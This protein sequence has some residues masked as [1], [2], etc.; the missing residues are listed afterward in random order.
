VKETTLEKSLKSR[1]DFQWL[2]LIL[3]IGQVTSATITA[4]LLFT[5]G[6]ERITY[7]AAIGSFLVALLSLTLKWRMKQIH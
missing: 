7:Y 2:L 4:Y 1:Q 3:G 6:L 5:L